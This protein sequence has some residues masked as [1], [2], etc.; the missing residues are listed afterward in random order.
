MNTPPPGEAA[1]ASSYISTTNLHLATFLASI[2]VAP[3]HLS[4]ENGRTPQG[5]RRLRWWFHSDPLAERAMALWEAFSPTIPA[6]TSRKAEPL[7][8]TRPWQELPPEVQAEVVDIITAT[9]SN[10]RHF[11]AMAKDPTG[12]SRTIPGSPSFSPAPQGK[13]V[14]G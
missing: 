4:L 8:K 2:G 3:S 14:P 7:P 12:A 9:L 10:L 13:A 1:T 5:D 6:I 11:L